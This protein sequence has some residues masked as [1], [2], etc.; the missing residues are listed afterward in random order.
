MGATLPVVAR[1]LVASDSRLGRTSAVL[2]SVE[3]ARRRARRLPV[4]LLDDPGAGRRALACSSRPPPTSRWPRSRW[5]AARGAAPGGADAPP[6]AADAPLA[7]R[8]VGAST[9]LCFAIS[10]FVAIGYEIIWSKVFGI[11]ME[12]TL[13]GF[14]AVLAGFLLGIGARQRRD[15]R[16]R[17]PHP[18]ARRALS[19]C[20][21]SRSPSASRPAC[22]RSP[23]FPT[24]TRGSR[25]PP[26][27]ATPCTGSSRWCC[28]WC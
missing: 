12:G 25:S 10:G 2:Y 11:V 23:S 15:R 8:G 24:P 7:R 20:C 1:G 28:R 18:R 9:L 3:H 17:G 19:R 5:R 14:A 21:I 13:Y 27:A 26:E 22:T 4:R 16:P 6:A